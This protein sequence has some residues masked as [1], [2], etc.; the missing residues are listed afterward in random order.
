M[1]MKEREQEDVDTTYH[2][3]DTAQNRALVNMESRKFSDQ[4]KGCYLPKK[5]SAQQMELL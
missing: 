2:A 5:D 3:W 4:M 1:N